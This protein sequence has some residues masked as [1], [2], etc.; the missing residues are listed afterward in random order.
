MDSVLACDNKIGSKT[1]KDS[2][3]YDSCAFSKNARQLHYVANWPEMTI[4]DYVARIGAIIIARRVPTHHRC[5]AERRK[6]PPLRL[7]PE[8]KNF[9]WKIEFRTETIGEF[10]FVHDYDHSCARLGD[11]LLTQQCATT[12]FNQIPLWIDFISAVDRDV[13]VYGEGIV[14]QWNA[15]VTR[16]DISLS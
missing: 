12:A 5:R 11:D 6:E 2:V 9:N 8:P 3:F 16:L 13:H 15:E 1:D 14:E 7:P 4:K 10:V